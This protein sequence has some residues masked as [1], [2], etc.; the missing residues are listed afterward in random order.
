MF[1]KFS[2]QCLSQIM[3]ARETLKL[4]DKK[5]K[6]NNNKKNSLTNLEIKE[7]K[8]SLNVRKGKSQT[9]LRH[10]HEDKIRGAEEEQAAG[11]TG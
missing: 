11:K 2:L 9:R 7:R 10:A 1:N 4:S 8:N 6:E 3:L 5:K